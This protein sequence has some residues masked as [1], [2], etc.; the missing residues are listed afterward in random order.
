MTTEPPDPMQHLARVRDAVHSHVRRERA[1]R[2]VDIGIDPKAD[3]AV[4]TP[5]IRV[6]VAT[7]AD[8]ERL[9]RTGLVPQQWEGV[10]IVVTVGDYRLEG[11][12]DR[13]SSEPPS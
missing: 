10:P 2:L 7:S 3:T 8:A 9:A 12:E 1:V 4:A 11:G 13:S 6:H 5:V